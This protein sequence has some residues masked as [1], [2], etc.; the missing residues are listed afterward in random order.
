[1]KG[2][3]DYFGGY[4]IYTVSTIFCIDST[5]EGTRDYDR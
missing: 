4:D 3:G 2:L 1:M 5:C